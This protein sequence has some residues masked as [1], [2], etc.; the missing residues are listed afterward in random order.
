MCAYCAMDWHHRL[1]EFSYSSCL[2]CSVAGV[3]SSRP[4]LD[5]AFTIYTK[6]DS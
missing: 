4:D 5:T 6:M 2:V 1:G 3:G